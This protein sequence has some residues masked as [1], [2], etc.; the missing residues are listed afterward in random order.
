[1]KTYVRLE[2]GIG[3]IANMA[4]DDKLD[5]DLVALKADHLF[6]PSTTHIGWRRGLLLRE[7]M[8]EFIHL[9]AP[10]L[11]P[12]VIQQAEAHNDDAA[13]QALVDSLWDKLPRI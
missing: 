10:H 8:V 9:F 12:E 6:E 13:H 5:K 3:I 1:I 11:T 2:L 7:Y 4:Y